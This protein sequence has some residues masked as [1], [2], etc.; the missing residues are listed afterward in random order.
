MERLGDLDH[1][2]H[3]EVASDT[4]QEDGGL[5]DCS[6][7]TVEAAVIDRRRTQL[8]VLLHGQVREVHHLSRTGDR[9]VRHDL[10]QVCSK[11]GPVWSGQTRDNEATARS[12]SRQV[13][14]R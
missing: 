14:A 12:G 5:E 9:H 11:S 2:H 4:N 13:A 3:Q 6:D 8:L 7:E 1:H 10:S